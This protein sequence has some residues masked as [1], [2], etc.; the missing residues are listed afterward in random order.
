MTKIGIDG[1]L[2]QKIHRNL[3]ECEQEILAFEI[4]Y[5]MGF[6]EFSR[7]LETGQLGDEFQWPLEADAM[8]WQD[9][10]E[11]KRHWQ[12]AKTTQTLK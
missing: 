6:Q 1:E 4:R 9:L 11:E 2:G 3:S 10:I 5:G 8:R 12:A 7:Q